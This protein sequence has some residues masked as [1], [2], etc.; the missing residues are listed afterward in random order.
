MAKHYTLNCSQYV[1]MDGD[2]PI[3]RVLDKVS[4][5]INKND[6]YLQKHGDPE[7]VESW[8]ARET[9][10]LRNS[11]LHEFANAFVVV[12]GRFP[13]DEVNKCLENH[14]YAGHFYKG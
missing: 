8:H 10:K 2:R 14:E 11:G 1:L 5:C 9:A 6:G 4:L 13:V 12:S 7:R 3:G